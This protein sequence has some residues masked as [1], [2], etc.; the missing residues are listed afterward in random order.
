MEADIKKKTAKIMKGK[1]AFKNEMDK[2]L[3]ASDR[4]RIWRD[5]HKRLYKMYAEHRDLSY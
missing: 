1:K 3:L 4:D 2:R 5:A